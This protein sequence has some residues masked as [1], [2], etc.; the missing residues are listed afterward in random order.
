MRN[1]RGLGSATRKV[2]KCKAPRSSKETATTKRATENS[3]GRPS[4]QRGSP[5]TLHGDCV[6][7]V[8]S[9]SAMLYSF[10]S[11][12]LLPVRLSQR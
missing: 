11:Y 12:K 2:Y 9:E 7:G 10:P 1:P 4:G 8:V 3:L 5:I 6:W